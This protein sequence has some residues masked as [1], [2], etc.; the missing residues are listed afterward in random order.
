MLDN[1]HCWAA[2]QLFGSA[3]CHPTFMRQSSRGFTAIACSFG[4]RRWH[5]PCPQSHPTCRASNK[6]YDRA[7]E[8]LRF[9]KSTFTGI[10]QCP[11]SLD[12]LVMPVNWEQ[13]HWVLAVIDFRNLTVNVL[14]SLAKVRMGRCFQLFMLQDALLISLSSTGEKDQR[15]ST[16]QQSCTGLVAA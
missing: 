13:N 8:W 11:F 12:R 4:P 1:G 16:S 3:T 7:E 6:D 14:D 10:C 2:T 15:C 9:D 5:P